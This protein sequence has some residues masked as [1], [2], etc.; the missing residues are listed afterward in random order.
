MIGVINLSSFIEV[1]LSHSRA[2]GRTWLVSD[3]EDLS[4]YD[5]VN[6]LGDLM[7][8]QPKLFKVSPVGLKLLALC[9]GKRGEVERLTGSL[10]VDASP[11][12]EELDWHAVTTIDEELARTVAAFEL[13]LP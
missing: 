3:G 8:K 9:L 4:T 13:G 11:G 10:Q 2:V 1:C 12:I 5:L 6:R 7:K